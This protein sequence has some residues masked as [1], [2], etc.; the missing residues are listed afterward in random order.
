MTAARNFDWSAQDRSRA[1][2]MQDTQFASSL[3][4]KALERQY[5]AQREQRI[6]ADFNRAQNSLTRP[7]TPMTPYQLRNGG[8]IH[9]NAGFVMGG[10]AEKA[11]GI[12]WLSPRDQMDY[13]AKMAQVDADLELKNARAAQMMPPGV[14][15]QL[16]PV[17]YGLRPVGLRNGGEIH[18][19]KGGLWGAIKGAVGMGESDEAFA[20][21]KAAAEKAAAQAKQQQPNTM[22][23]VRRGLDGQGGNSIE[24][25]LK[26]AGAVNGGTLQTGKGGEVPGKGKGD[27][28]P[29]LYEPHEF[30]VSNDM[31]AA[32]PALLPHL[33]ELRKAVL[34]KKGMTPEQADAKAIHMDSEGPGDM[35]GSKDEKEPKAVKRG[36]GIRAEDSFFGPD[37]FGS[38][39]ANKRLVEGLA[40][41]QAAKDA[42]ANRAFVDAKGSPR[43]GLDKWIGVTNGYKEV[44]PKADSAPPES[45]DGGSRDRQRSGANPA[46]NANYSNEGRSIPAP[47]V[48]KPSAKDTPAVL[49]GATGQNVGFGVTR[50]NAPGQSPLFTNMTDAAG[51]A[52]NEALISRKPQSDQDRIATDN[53][54]ARGNA[55]MDAEARMAQRQAELQ[56]EYQ[57]GQVDNRAIDSRAR[58]TELAKEIENLNTHLSSRSLTPEEYRR[59]EK[60]LELLQTARLNEG[61]GFGLHETQLATNAATNATNFGIHAA[62]NQARLQGESMKLAQT[63]PGEAL[64]NQLTQQLVNA[65]A[66]YALAKTPEEKA[67][68]EHMLRAAQGK[69]D[70][71]KPSVVPLADKMAPDGFTK[72]NGGS[73]LYVPAADGGVGRFVSPSQS[74]AQSAGTQERVVGQIYVDA[75]GNRAKWDGKNFV[76][77]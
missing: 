51:M 15:T 69:W 68:A 9:A 28:I 11:N 12:K 2:G 40:A 62:D 65:Q 25:R 74:E 3:Q 55:R 56:A 72:L 70:A 19:A 18:A 5:R 22:P 39:K 47:P 4:D 71:F 16:K 33:R 43:I 57:Q 42:E 59:G 73:T 37:F 35:M 44:T 23:D 14:D 60:Q 75:K 13:Q 8:E 21:R 61:A 10:F 66:Q 58:Q 45:G 38:D 52:S 67:A 30:V 54:V 76:P 1:Q 27:K 6:A 36:F 46:T 49:Q 29:A 7:M 26:A 63:A 48:T 64:K 34:A 53:L 17:G 24:N 50:F 20:A 41:Q 31:L 77:A 32:D